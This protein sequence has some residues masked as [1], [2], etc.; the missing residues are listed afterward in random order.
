MDELAEGGVLL[1]RPADD[2][3]RPDRA[4]AVIDCSTCSTGKI[5]R[6]RVVAQVI[7]ERP[8]GQLP[9]GIDV[10]GDAE[11]GLGHDRQVRRGGEIMA[12]APPA[13]RAGEGHLRHPFGQ[14]HHGG[15]GHRRRPADEDV[16][17]QRLA[18]RDRRGMMDADA[19][20]DLVVQPDLAV[21]AYWL[22]ASCTRYMPRFEC[23]QPGRSASSV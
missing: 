12:H 2:R 13:Q 9:L 20:M 3:E 22:P 21:R 11:I 7:A 16:D 19:A 4:R 23:R 6:Q 18:S 1:R 15:H 17:P 5:V 8:F 10:A 14:R